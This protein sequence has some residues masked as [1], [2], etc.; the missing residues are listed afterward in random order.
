MPVEA[1]K[2]SRKYSE[3]P[4]PD[5]HIHKQLLQAPGQVNSYREENFGDIGVEVH[6]MPGN[7]ARYHTAC[8]HFQSQCSSTGVPAT[9]MAPPAGMIFIVDVLQFERG[10]HN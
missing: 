4:V 8:D 6:R 2:T 9:E 5:R 1:S 7:H 3:N 10:T